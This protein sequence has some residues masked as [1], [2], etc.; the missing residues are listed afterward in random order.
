M[1]EWW[2][3]RMELREYDF[4][5]VPRRTKSYHRMLDAHLQFE[6]SNMWRQSSEILASKSVK[7]E[8]TLILDNQEYYSMLLYSNA[9]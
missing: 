9:L 7:G 8:S 2:S 1:V 3:S 4:G 6:V 5:A